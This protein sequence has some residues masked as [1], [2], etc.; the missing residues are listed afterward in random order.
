[1]RCD[2]MRRVYE[3]KLQDFYVAN[4]ELR[5]TKAEKKKQMMMMPMAPQPPMQQQQVSILR[6]FRGQVL[7]LP[8]R[9]K[10]D[11]Q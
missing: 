7:I 4:P 3:Q 11:H 1:M 2:D 10:F 6:V 8:L 9:V 5:P